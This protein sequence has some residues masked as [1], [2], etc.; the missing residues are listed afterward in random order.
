[1][2]FHKIDNPM[3]FRFPG[4]DGGSYQIDVLGEGV[5]S[6]SVEHERWTET[7]SYAPFFEKSFTLEDRK[8]ELIEKDGRLDFIYNGNSLLRTKVDR[9]FGVSGSKWMFTFDY[10]DEMHFYGMGEK[11]NGFEKSGIK[12]KFWNTDVWGDFPVSEVVH[13]STDP[14]YLSVPYL[15]IKKEDNWFGI[16]VDNP[17]PV[18]MATGAE[19]TIAKQNNSDTSKDFYLGSVNGKP[20]LYFITGDDPADVTSKLQR[21]TGP[22]SR[23]PLWSLG[24]HQCRWGYKSYEDLKELDQRFSQ[25]DIPCDGLWLDIDY[26]NGYRVFTWNKEHFKKLKDEIA[27]LKQSERNVVPILDPG[28]KRD[29][30]FPVYLDGKDKNVFCK[31]TEGLEYTGFVWPGETMFPD[32]SIE[33]VRKWWAEKVKE[34]ASVGIKG[35]WIDMNDPATGSSELD[36]MRF[37]HGKK[38]HEYFHNQYS[39]AM[40]E[41]TYDGLREAN[42]DNRPFILSRSGFTGTSRWSAIWTGDNFSNYHNLRKNIETS[43]NL[44]ISSIPFIGSDVP[45][46]GGDATGELMI[47]WFK[48]AFLSPV[49]RNHSLK[50]TK[51]QEPWAFNDKVLKVVSHYIRLRYKLLPY[52]Y[53]LFI[54]LENKGEPVL[55][56]LYYHSTKSEV[57]NMLYIDDQFYTGSSILHAPVVN[58][59][60]VER[61]LYLPA[62]RWFEVLSGNFVD[63]NK[64]ASFYDGTDEKTPLYIRDGSM[65][66][67]LPGIRL[68]NQ[69]DLSEIELHVFADRNSIIEDFNYSYDAGDGYGY[70]TG[71]ES[72]FSI[73]GEA[74]GDILELEIIGLTN[75]YKDCRLEFVLY[76]KFNQILVTSHGAVKVLETEKYDWNFAMNL[77][78]CW[79]SEIVIV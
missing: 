52:L 73:R 18:F 72:S 23:P 5:I 58:E 25:Y 8:A 54:E 41:A 34:F 13:H 50:D 53:N 20:H 30:D 66:P 37:D 1:M 38:N 27:D 33:E 69:S 19:E 43:L 15:L 44:S 39:L 65:I 35:V 14:M 16:L 31:N 26:M 9:T 11:S 56:P 78:R 12:T 55:R 51:E 48:A 22:V 47:S 24:Y 46:F 61:D 28:V 64:I 49:L 75:G 67:M 2:Y 62:G 57:E 21:L 42:P 63:G 45:G 60:E 10:C 70:K 6:L 7:G 4:L 76:H 40:Q 36:E 71:E 74:I 79:K 29:S 68:N 3:N 77:Q 32:F 59:G 17:Y